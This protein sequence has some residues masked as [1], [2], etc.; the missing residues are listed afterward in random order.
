MKIIKFKFFYSHSLHL[1]TENILINENNC[2]YVFS[3][4]TQ[5]CQCSDFDYFLILDELCQT[6]LP[7]FFPREKRV[8]ILMESPLTTKKINEQLLTKRFDLVLTHR[9]ELINNGNPF[10]LLYFSTNLIGQKGQYWHNQDVDLKIEKNK[11]V[12]FVGGIDTFFDCPGYIL[13]KKIATHPLIVKKVDRFG[14]GINF[15]ENKKDGLLNYCF[16]IA[17]E[18]T[19]ENHYFSEKIIDCFLTETIPI[20][21]G[22][23]SITQIFDSRGIIFFDSEDDLIPLISSLSMEKYKQMLPYA[24]V[25]KEICV[26]NN[27]DS[28]EGFLRRCGNSISSTK[29]YLLNKKCSTFDTSKFMAAFRK[30]ILDK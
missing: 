26:K 17:M 1:T 11:L 14:K 4:S 27:L 21:W 30:Y 18:N 25:N 24:K 13:R 19:R 5:F 22:C 23:R 6:N 10:D 3:F 2:L 20:Y 15:I 28:F 12:S 16:S 8:A 29:S 7:F 9:E